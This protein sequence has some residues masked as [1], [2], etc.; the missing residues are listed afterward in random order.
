MKAL[1]I[2]LLLATGVW[3]GDSILVPQKI[4]N[5]T[6]PTFPSDGATVNELAT[7]PSQATYEWIQPK[8]TEVINCRTDSTGQCIAPIC[9]CEDMT[10]IINDQANVIKMYERLIELYEKGIDAIG[11]A[12]DKR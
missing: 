9:D 5:Q 8:I 10:R 7:V 11:K 2:V 12:L 4:V 1:L 3:A 6:F